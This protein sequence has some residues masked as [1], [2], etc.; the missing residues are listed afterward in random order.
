MPST[1]RAARASASVRSQTL[2][3]RHASACND[4]SD[5]YT[6]SPASAQTTTA[7]HGMPIT[8]VCRPRKSTAANDA[9]SHGVRRQPPEQRQ[10]PRDEDKRADEP[11]LDRQLGVGRLARL[12]RHVRPRRRHA[13]VAEAE[14]PRVVQRGAR[15][16]A[17]ARQVLARRRLV[18]AR[19]VVALDRRLVRVSLLVGELARREVR[20]RAEVVVRLARTR[21][22][23][24]RD[25]DGQA[26]EEQ[27]RAAATARTS[28]PSDER[29]QRSARVRPE[30]RGE[31]QRR[32]RPAPAPSAQRHEEQ[33]NDEQVARSR[34]ARGTSR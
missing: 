16:G 25:G 32:E 7:I 15:T 28:R 21:S 26:D 13:G 4:V 31:E 29:E 9:A 23:D 30:Q 12:D 20:A 6:S 8:S 19:R 34:A 10:R 11:G 24:R 5:R 3:S 22:R 18:R 1:L 33:R 27:P 14:S 17:E 2:R